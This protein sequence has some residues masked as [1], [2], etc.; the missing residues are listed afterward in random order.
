MSTEAALILALGSCVAFGGY[1][2]FCHGPPTAW[3]WLGGMMGLFVLAYRIA[4]R[5]TG[6]EDDQ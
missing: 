3:L 6:E 4:N 1:L 5:K 2:F